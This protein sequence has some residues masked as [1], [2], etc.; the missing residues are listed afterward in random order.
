MGIF[1]SIIVTFTGGL[2]VL[3]SVLSGMQYS[4]AYRM[5]FV[6]SMVGLIFF[7]VICYLCDFIYKIVNIENKK[8]YVINGTSRDKFNKFLIG[9]VIV[10]T[11]LYFA[12]KKALA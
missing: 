9:C 6:T 1:S 5:A 2:Q 11:I 4:S 12:N 8:S 10:T 7:N 3:G